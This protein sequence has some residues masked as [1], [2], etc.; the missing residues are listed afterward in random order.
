PKGTIVQYDNSPRRCWMWRT[1]NDQGLDGCKVAQFNWE[2]GSN[3]KMICLNCPDNGQDEKSNTDKG[4]I[5]INK[6]GVDIDIKDGADSF[7]MKIDGQGVQIRTNEKTNTE[8]VG[9]TVR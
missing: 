8:V 7:K 4:K 3:G 1:D 9:D 2:M 5:I 6:D